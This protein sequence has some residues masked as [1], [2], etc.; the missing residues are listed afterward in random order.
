MEPLGVLERF[1]SPATPVQREEERVAGI[2]YAWA[3]GIISVRTAKARKF[4]KILGL[5]SSGSETSGFGKFG[6]LLFET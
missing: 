4:P 2:V 3:A 6:D 1:P 5:A